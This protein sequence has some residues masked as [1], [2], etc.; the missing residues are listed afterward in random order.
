MIKVMGIRTAP[1][2]VRY[3]ILTK[4]EDGVIQFVNANGEN[5]IDFP[6]DCDNVTKKLPWLSREIQRIFRQNPEISHVIIK[7]SEYGRGGESSSSR[8]AAYYDSAVITQAGLQLRPISVDVK[9]YRGLGNNVK[10]DTVK[11][12]AEGHVGKTQKYWNE[13]IADAIVAALSFLGE[14]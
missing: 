7:A 3:A 12:I 8:E 4:N 6:A 10:R 9:I 1:S 13:Q 5:K 11:N 14:I 2:V